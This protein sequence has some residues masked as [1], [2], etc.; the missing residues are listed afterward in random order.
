M[1]LALDSVLQVLFLGMEREAIPCRLLTMKVSAD[2][3]W[4]QGCDNLCGKLKVPWGRQVRTGRMQRPS[5]A[6]RANIEGSRLRRRRRRM[7]TGT[8]W[9]WTILREQQIPRGFTLTA[10]NTAHAAQQQQYP[11]LFQGPSAAGG[12]H[13]MKVSFQ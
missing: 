3:P 12:W 7:S 8:R 6:V 4:Q 11:G 9:Q 5:P 1:S 13:H 2:L 10:Q